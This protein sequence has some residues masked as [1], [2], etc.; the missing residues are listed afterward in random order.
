LTY[1]TFR[2]GR[3]EREG[4]KQKRKDD[5]SNGEKRKMTQKTA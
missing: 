2:D 4:E 5:R 1:K 3:E